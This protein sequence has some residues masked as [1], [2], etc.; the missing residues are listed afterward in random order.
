[1]VCKQFVT[2]LLYTVVKNYLKWVSRKN[3]LILDNVES[4]T[5]KNKKVPIFE[6]I[7]IIKYLSIKHWVKLLHYLL[8]NVESSVN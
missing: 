1:M 8:K 4:V 2:L 7:Y 5:V 3:K 6:L